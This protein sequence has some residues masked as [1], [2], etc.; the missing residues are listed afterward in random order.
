MRRRLAAVG[1]LAGSMCMLLPAVVSAHVYEVDL[2]CGG[3]FVYMNAYSSEQGSSN[4]LKIFIDDKLEVE[5][6][7]DAGFEE[8]FDV[9][10]PTRAHDVRVEV[11][12]F[13]DDNGPDADNNGEPSWSF[14]WA[15]TIGACQ[16]PTPA[17]T[18]REAHSW[19]AVMV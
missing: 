13:D 4:T 7:F 8:T 18:P 14:D 1:V 2:D 9:G 5:R 15:D 17:P 19:R 16:E 11:R 6:S 10:D 12:A 3:L